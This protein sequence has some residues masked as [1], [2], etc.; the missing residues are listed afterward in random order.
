[1]KYFTSRWRVWLEKKK[2]NLPGLKINEKKK[3]NINRY[4]HSNA[5]TY[6]D[7]THLHAHSHTKAHAQT[8]RAEAVDRI[9]PS[10]SGSVVATPAASPLPVMSDSPGRIHHL[11]G[12]LGASQLL[13]RGLAGDGSREALG[14]SL[15]SLSSSCVG[16]RE[17]RGT[18]V[19]VW[20]QQKVWLISASAMF[21]IPPFPGRKKLALDHSQLNT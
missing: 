11:V 8:H 4:R 3:T 20:S 19:G 9:C 12:S 16:D 21:V 18:D 13:P 14:W 6:T 7:A 15:P 17:R 10:S 5:C 2:K 1:M